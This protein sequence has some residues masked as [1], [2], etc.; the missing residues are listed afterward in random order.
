MLKTQNKA[1]TF[2]GDNLQKI[3]L[4]NTYFNTRGPWT[5]FIKVRR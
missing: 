3:N 5:A 2:S 4:V 1:V